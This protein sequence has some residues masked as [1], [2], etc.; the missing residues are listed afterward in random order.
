[1]RTLLAVLLLFT[2]TLAMAA[3]WQQYDSN[4]DQ[5]QDEL[6]QNQIKIQQQRDA[7]YEMDRRQ[8]EKNAE[9]QRQKDD[10]IQ[11]EAWEIQKQQYQQYQQSRPPSIKNGQLVY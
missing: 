3:Q 11:Q 8:Y 9:W 4:S 2:S 1:M 6:R 10:K 7:Q 5:V